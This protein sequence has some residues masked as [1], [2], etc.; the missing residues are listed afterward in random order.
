MRHASIA[1]VVDIVKRLDSVLMVRYIR[2]CTCKNLLEIVYPE[3]YMFRCNVFAHVVAP[4]ESMVCRAPLI[5]FFLAGNSTPSIPHLFSQRKVSGFPFRCA[6]TAAANGR[7]G[8]N[9]YEVNQWLRQFGRG[10]PRLGGLT[11]KQTTLSLQ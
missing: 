2:V 4:A 10:R 9:V 7:R 3:T 11:V 5:R 1:H 8:S 6:D